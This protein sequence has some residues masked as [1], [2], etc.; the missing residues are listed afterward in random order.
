M[1][2]RFRRPA[3]SCNASFRRCVTPRAARSPTPVFASSRRWAA[4]VVAV[5]DRVAL[6]VALDALLQFLRVKG[7]RGP[8]VL[9][10]DVTP[11]ID[12]TDF[13]G[14]QNTVITLQTNA[15][16]ALPITFAGTLSTAP[17]RYLVLAGEVTLGAAAGTWLNVTVGYDDGVTFIPVEAMNYTGTIAGATYRVAAVVRGLILP[18]QFRAR[19]DIQGNAGGA[20]HVAQLRYSY[21]RLDGLP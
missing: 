13:Y 3:P 18:A 17:R 9:S 7:G 12:V 1:I 2:F 15:A 10:L 5:A 4:V 11:E 6:Q 16:A 14:I 20:D 8:N 21:Q 19:V